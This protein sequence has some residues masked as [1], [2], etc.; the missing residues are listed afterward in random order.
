MNK[1]RI[2]IVSQYFYPEQFKINDIA[3]AWYKKGFEVTVLTGIPNYPQ[4][5]FYPG[6]G[7]LKKRTEIYNGIRIIRIPLIPRGHNKILLIANYYSFV[8]SGWFWK[9][10]TNL[11][12]DYVVNFIVSPFT[13]AKVGAWFAHRRKIPFYVYVQDLWPE[14]VIS[15]VGNK[16]KF[17]LKQIDHM[18]D[19]IYKASD[20]VLVTSHS[21]ANNIKDRGV[22]SDKIFFFPQYAESFYKP[23]ET[24]SN[25][26]NA[27]GF[28]NVTFTGNIGSAQG[29]QI[30]PHVALY[31][32]KNNEDVRFNIVGDGR[33][34]NNLVKLV[35]DIGVNKYFNFIPIQKPENIPSI[36]ASSDCAFLSFSADPV[37]KMTIPAKLQTYL[38]C[39]MPIIASAEGETQKII[40]E[41]H[42]GYCVNLDDALSLYNVI[43]KFKHDSPEKKAQ[44]A[45]NSFEYNR[46]NFDK[47]RLIDYSLSLL[48]NS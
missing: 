18:V 36:L 24:K 42:C 4:G 5:K 29:L 20:K 1:K 41:A 31:L 21:F 12:T 13:Q 34:K 23:V 2:L 44:M 43:V 11:K 45:H 37:F 16:H 27:D 30:L 7:I 38:A 33:E 17:I 10:F 8:I 39:G 15:I 6:Y 3:Q 22:S 32:K 28:L 14:N 40:H 26:I 19:K 47:E 46:I 48:F 9:T 25:L 35:K